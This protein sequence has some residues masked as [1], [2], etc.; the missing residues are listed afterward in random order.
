MRKVV[1]R[2]NEYNKYL[3]IKNLIDNNGN[4]NTATIKL[5][6]SRRQVVLLIIIYKD[7]GKSGFVHDNHQSYHTPIL[8]F[9]PLFEIKL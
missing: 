1:L 6:I 5:N 2:M 3:I 4:K 9:S 8:A 7:K